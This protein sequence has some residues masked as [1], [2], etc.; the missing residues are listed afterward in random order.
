MSATRQLLE[1]QIDGS[2]V[3]VGVFK[4]P[5]AAER[6][7]GMLA[8]DGFSPQNIN[9]VKKTKAEVEEL[10]PTTSPA[11]NQALAEPEADRMQG[12]VAVG[13]TA[14]TTSRINLGTGIGLL[15]GAAGGA[16]TGLALLNVPGIGPLFASGGPV[17]AMLVFGLIGSVLGALGG[18][19]AGIGASEEDTSYFTDELEQGGYLVAVRTNRLDEAIDVLHDAGALNLRDDNGGH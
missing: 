8:A 11:D 17:V 4:D 13:A 9:V 18:S 2:Q 14:E 12:Q 19:L 6:A 7:R 5:Q 15:T 3:I 1:I 16:A 10:A